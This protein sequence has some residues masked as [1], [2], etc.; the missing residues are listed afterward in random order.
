MRVLAIFHR[1]GSRAFPAA[2]PPGC[3][4]LRASVARRLDGRRHAVTARAGSACTD[5]TAVGEVLISR[6]GFVDVPARAA[7]APPL[8]YAAATHCHTR[9]CVC[10]AC[11]ASASSSS[12]SLASSRVSPPA[13][14]HSSLPRGARPLRRFFSSFSTA[15]AESRVGDMGRFNTGGVAVPLGEA[16]N[17]SA[18]S[19][20]LSFPAVSEVFSRY[21]S[22][23]FRERLAFLAP[24]LGSDP[25]RV[26]RRPTVSLLA[27]LLRGRLHHRQVTSSL[28][29]AV[30]SAPLPSCLS[31]LSPSS[32]ASPA[33][34]E[35]EV[36]LLNSRPPVG[37]ENFFPDRKSRKAGNDGPQAGEA[38]EGAAPKKES[39]REEGREDR[40]AKNDKDAAPGAETPTPPPRAGLFGNWGFGGA[41]PQK[42]DV[43]SRGDRPQAPLGGKSPD[44]VPPALRAPR[45]RLYGKAGQGRSDEQR[46]KERLAEAERFQMPPKPPRQPL[47]PPPPP[48]PGSL[49]A[50]QREMLKLVAWFG[51]SSVFLYN[52][53]RS[54]KQE[55]SM[56]EFLSKYVAN[57]LVDRIEVLGDR[58][59]CRA[60]VNLAPLPASGAAAATSLGDSPTGRGPSGTA[61]LSPPRF[62]SH[63]PPGVETGFFQA[64]TLPPGKAVVRFRSGLSA[65]SF[66]EKMES[67]Q[68][69]LGIHPRDFLPI[70]IGDQQ[71]FHLFD[72]LGSLFLFFLIANMI[73]E[74]IFMRRMRKGGSGGPGA[75]GAAGG[76]NRLL[77][78]SASRRARVKA[79]TVKVRFSDVAGLHEAKR[80]ILEFVSFLKNPQS[81]RRLGAKLPKGAL[82]VG[83]PGTGK[84][85][86]AKAVAGEAGVPFFS[87]SGSEFVEIF[88]GVGASRVRELFDEARKVAPSIIFIDEID[89]VGAKRSTSFGNSERDN[90]LNQLLVE[91]DG[92]NP[93]QTVVVLAGT[94]R[95]DLLDDALKRPGRFDR[96]V[97]IRRPDVKERKEIFKV[98]LKP[99]RLAPTIDSVALAERM[100]ALTPGFVGA[101]IANLCN[102]AAIQAA[103]RRSKLGVEQQDFESATE[104]TIAG[105]PSAVKDLL[106]PQQRR[107]IAYH[108][109][110]HAIAG[111]FLKHGNPVL[112]LTII[113]R[114]SGALGFAQQMPPTVELHEKDAL[115]D[116]IAVLLAGR[117]AEEIFIGAISSGAADD[118]QKASRLARLSVMQ[119]GM[120]E[121]LGLV[122][123]GLQQQGGE[124]AFYRPYSEHTAKL[125]DE[126]VHR[127]VQEQYERAKALLREREKEVHALCEL[128]MSRESITYSEI[129]E[130][131]GP[132]PVPPDPQMAAYIQALP[133]R[134]LLPATSQES[135]K[136][137]EPQEEKRDKDDD[138]LSGGRRTLD[139][140]DDATMPEKVKEQVRKAAEAVAARKPSSG[141]L[142]CR[143]RNGRDET[144]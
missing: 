82:L 42:G 109:C 60:I 85:L 115:L 75:G 74:V 52:L 33:L 24:S 92:F 103:R 40:P 112:K 5:I 89:S 73:S 142:A 51:L 105:L 127:M 59:D 98:H 31:V 3:A 23:S 62:T 49:G 21:E 17:A 131:V 35:L 48:P 136:E 97:Q 56:Q 108:E 116:R 118:I 55:M 125:I 126:E 138:D 93:D 87:M 16:A 135:S 99:L 94:N 102:E 25:L 128:L 72:F 100:A 111:W 117:A 12:E 47:S 61:S 104:R 84:T 36:A 65:E 90:T 8:A 101:D 144:Q 6:R 71:E 66:I 28:P 58:G 45:A 141:P 10:R 27:Q 139:D 107:A 110:G 83:P 79:E 37:F 14:P 130:C 124:Q 96:L 120:N 11:V 15:A 19:P 77:G 91:M 134:P 39:S 7:A 53:L 76:L 30:A 44:G 38:H 143:V 119:F 86:L 121:T 54:R 43:R 41:P 46:E 26:A 9:R 34:A 50:L 81:F 70:H 63:P 137:E 129:L 123:Y 132:R 106:S 67:F 140:N 2:A 80:E 4:S 57:G 88:V 68:T 29:S 69:S 22:S 18:A 13:A 32:H 133:T 122:D 20:L 114:S 64:L 95:E 113:P 78:N 1:G